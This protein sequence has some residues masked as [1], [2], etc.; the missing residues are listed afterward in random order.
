MSLALCASDGAE[1]IED[2]IEREIE[3]KIPSKNRKNVIDRVRKIAIDAMRKGFRGME[4]A[5]AGSRF[6]A[7]ATG[8]TLALIAP[9]GRQG[10]ERAF[11]EAGI[12]MGDDI[13]SK[14]W[15]AVQNASEA[16]SKDAALRDAGN[17][18]SL[19]AGV[20]RLQE[21]EAS[22][23]AALATS[24]MR[25][26]IAVEKIMGPL[27]DAVQD[28]KSGRSGMD[29]LLRLRS[30]SADMDF[31][32]GDHGPLSHGAREQKRRAARKARGLPEKKPY[33]IRLE[34]KWEEYRA[35]Q[36]TL[37][38][39]STSGHSLTNKATEMA[40]TERALPGAPEDGELKIALIGQRDAQESGLS[41]AKDEYNASLDNAEKRFPGH[42]I[43][44]SEAR[45]IASL[46]E[47]Q[48][49]RGEILAERDKLRKELAERLGIDEKRLPSDPKAF[50]MFLT[51][52]EMS[53][54]AGIG[55]VFGMYKTVDDS[56]ATV[57]AEILRQK[58]ETLERAKADAAASGLPPPAWIAHFEND[59]PSR[60][61]AAGTGE[62]RGDQE[63]EGRPAR[64]K[65]DEPQGRDSPTL[66]G[67]AAAAPVSLRN[68]GASLVATVG[69]VEIPFP[70]SLPKAEAVRAAQTFEGLK[71]TAFLDSTELFH[72]AIG[73][74]NK[75]HF[76]RKIDLSK[77]MTRPM[78]QRTLEMA[79]TL[80][81]GKT[82]PHADL[83]K[84]EPR[85]FAL[86]RAT[87]EELKSR[88]AE[89]GK[90]FYDGGQWNLVELEKRFRDAE[91]AS[92]DRKK[93]RAPHAEAGT[94]SS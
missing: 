76:D 91:R 64:A 87:T 45:T 9:D 90:A 88:L 47:L 44:N 37:L 7:A 22:H 71:L 54:P 24:G 33:E 63:R 36:G 25:K 16:L 83:S 40:Y 89:N 59:S 13:R 79:E 73:L 46:I 39:V 30:A 5:I 57:D 94:V 58:R 48:E 49:K 3:V 28:M 4:A 50:R 41:A 19:V 72:D 14:N 12:G 61:P 93:G 21:N 80:F 18:L 56:L 10:I 15:R 60:Q 38:E 62:K 23:S 51:S 11:R 1:E 92:P 26:D 65:G 32:L 66:P 20:L 84:L 86:H 52:L 74:W 78:F 81:D 34:N 31:F 42:P 68:E 70:K 67:R 82:D 35:T 77:G 8:E 43:A 27:E 53:L 75:I 55:T 69:N 85:A 2:A 17:F 29:G 6:A